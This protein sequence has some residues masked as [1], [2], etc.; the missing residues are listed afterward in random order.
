MPPVHQGSDIQHPAPEPTSLTTAVPH[1]GT[2]MTAREGGSEHPARVAGITAAQPALPWRSILL[3][4]AV[5]TVL[6]IVGKA[7]PALC[8]RKE[9]HWRHRLAL[10]VGMLPRGAVGAG[11]LVLSLS[12]GVGGPV[13]T[14]AILVLALNLA[15]TGAFIA[16]MKRL[17]NGVP[18]DP[19]PVPL[20]SRPSDRRTAP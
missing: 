3:H 5:I 14:I 6:S 12:Y 17:A 16:A 19:P 13:V 15:L 1:A 18:V 2:E 7:V 20:S 10:A 4:V 9:A 8:Y 11:V